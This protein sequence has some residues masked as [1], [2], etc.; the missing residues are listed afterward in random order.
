MRKGLDFS[1]QKPS[2]AAIK[3]GG[4][5]FVIRY[6]SYNETGKN[7]TKAE[8]DAY[9]ANQIDVVSV[10]E[11]DARDALKGH[12]LGHKHAT[13]ADKLHC[14]C[15]GPPEAP[16]YF[17]V[18]FDATPEEQ[19]AINSYL[20]GAAAAI[21]LKRV[22]VYGGYYPVLRCAEA[23][24]A[25]Y[26]WQTYAWS[27][28]HW[29]DRAHL[30]QVENG[31]QVGGAEVD[32]N[33]A[34]TDYF[35]QWD[36]EPPPHGSWL[37]VHLKTSSG[38]YLCAENGGGG[39]L[40]ATPRTAEEWE[41]FDL[42]SVDGYYVRPAAAVVLRTCNGHYVRAENGGGGEVN[43]KSS[44]NRGW[45]SFTLVRTDNSNESVSTGASIALRAHKGEYVCA[46]HGGGDKVVANR[47]S[48]TSWGTF[49]VELA[50]SDANPVEAKIDSFEASKTKG[51]WKKIPKGDLL[52]DMR[53]TVRNP[54][55]VDQE[56]SPLCGP[57]AI[58]FELARRHPIDYVKICRT[59]F[60]TGELKA[61]KHTEKPRQSLLDSKIKSR[62]TPADWMLMAAMRDVEN[63]VFPVDKDSNEFVM[64]LTGLTTPCE[65]KGWTADLLEF[66]DVSF[67]ST[68]VYGEFDTMRKAQKAVDSGGV[69]FL[70]VHSSLLGGDKPR[71][72]HPD[73]WVSLLGGTDIDDGEWWKHDSGHISFDCYSWGKQ[74]HVDVG[75]GTFEDC[76][77][78][79]VIGTKGHC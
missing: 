22:G 58:V 44:L 25:T 14:S 6:L 68:F 51:L 23:G 75:E 4:Y 64:G 31:I 72:N 59:L 66:D 54:F 17:A 48:V 57:A 45:E 77:W 60:E 61:G 8:A 52:T 3:K 74:H 40:T 62:V 70:L 34:M 41:T 35:G 13:Y 47:K 7:L 78:G 33:H 10:W 27:G 24:T 28:G 39:A 19:A 76:M 21:G 56:S 20:S 49:I 15:G 73:H 30:R 5:D 69:A 32:R 11:S 42:L 37:R 12:D 43:A 55:N 50:G 18:D 1:W 26:F 71:V 46:D 63:S 79:A 38:H 36:D 67:D 9:R 65:M 53:G 29:F 16:I 2:V